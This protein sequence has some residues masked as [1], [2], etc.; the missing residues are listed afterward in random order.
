VGLNLSLSAAQA[1]DFGL[2]LDGRKQ[3]VERTAEDIRQLLPDIS[4]QE[5]RRQAILLRAGAD[6]VPCPNVPASYV[7]RNKN[8]ELEKLGF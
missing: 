3:S 8:L 2:R 4:F 7:T 5:A 1:T 6:I